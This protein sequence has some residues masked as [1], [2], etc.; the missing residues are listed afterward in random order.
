MT[1]T[2]RVVSPVP[3]GSEAA[4]FSQAVTIGLF[5]AALGILIYILKAK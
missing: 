4:P 3:V 2:A 1:R 5:V